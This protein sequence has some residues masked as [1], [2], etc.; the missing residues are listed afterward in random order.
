MSYVD[1][2]PLS[3]ASNGD[4]YQDADRPAGKHA[5]NQFLVGPHYFETVGIRLVQGRDFSPG[6]DENTS[7][8]VHQ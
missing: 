8:A 1:I 2:M 7:V 4:N 3:L 5:A 6:R